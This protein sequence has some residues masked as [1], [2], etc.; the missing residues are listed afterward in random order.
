MYQYDV[1]KIL[2][3]REESRS[4]LVTREE[5]RGMDK[6]C[7][8]IDF[9]GHMEDLIEITAALDKLIKERGYEYI[10]VYSYGVPTDIYEKAG[11]VCCNEDDENIIPNYFHPF[12]RKNVSLR[13]MDPLLPGLRLFRGDG[14]QDRPC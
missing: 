4:V 9:Y 12:V 7:K 5:K 3:D 13:M 2:D 10:D 11:F 8:I 1:L 14:D 6:I